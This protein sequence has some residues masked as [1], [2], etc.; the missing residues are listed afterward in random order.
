MSPLRF[1]LLC[2]ALMA[3]IAG[4]APTVAPTGP[5]I[6]EPS[7]AG[8][9]LVMADGNERTFQAWLPAGEPQAVILA[10]H[11]FNDYANAFAAPGEAWAARGIATF[12]YDQRGFGRDTKPGIWPGDEAMVDDALAALRLL[13]QRYPGVPVYL[14]GESMGGAVATLAAAHN[15]APMA[16][17]LILVAPAVWARNTMPVS[18]RVGLWLG[19]HLAPSMTLR[20]SN[21]EIW[22]SDNIEMLRAFSADPLVIKETRIDAVYGLVNLMD[23]AVVKPGDIALPTLVVYGANDQIVPAEPVGLFVA[24]LPPGSRVAVYED[25]YHMLLR[26]LEARVVIDDIAAWI[27]APQTPLPSDAEVLAATFFIAPPEPPATPRFLTARP[28]PP[29]RGS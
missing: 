14:L 13:Q 3:V 6:V 19:A 22:P 18:Y 17:G 24:G 11:G 29:K 2:G 21:L 1:V 28:D 10:L 15:P 9:T 20:G 7:I 4:C 25:G 23:A 12:A 16:D 5:K 26:D 27:T 8:D